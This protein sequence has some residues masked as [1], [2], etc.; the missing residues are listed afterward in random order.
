MPR[1]HPV[2]QSPPGPLSSPGVQEWLLP[3]SQRQVPKAWVGML[4]II[5]LSW[6]GLK[7]AQQVLHRDPSIPEYLTEARLLR[8]VL[9]SLLQGRS[10]LLTAQARAPLRL[11]LRA[12]QDGGGS[13]SALHAW[14]PAA[15]ALEPCGLS[16]KMNLPAG[17]LRPCMN[18]LPGS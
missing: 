18:S 9:I 1:A 12:V 3:A 13:G 15:L 7:A 11:G 5:L 17:L 10:T 16:I 2:G 4:W 8:L 14:E 6:V